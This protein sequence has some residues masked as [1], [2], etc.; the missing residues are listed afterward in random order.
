MEKRY[1]INNIMNS[2]NILL[3]VK[4][5][6]KIMNKRLYTDSISVLQRY[7]NKW[8]QYNSYIQK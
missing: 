6:Q 3:K 4:Y 8:K 5:L 1:T 7:I 2:T